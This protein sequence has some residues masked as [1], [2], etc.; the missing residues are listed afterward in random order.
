MVNLICSG[1]DIWKQVLGLGLL[2]LFQVWQLGAQVPQHIGVFEY[3]CVC[4]TKMTTT[5]Y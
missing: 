1:G 4:G 5:H 2:T 3:C